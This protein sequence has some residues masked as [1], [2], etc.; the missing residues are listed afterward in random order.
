MSFASQRQ[1]DD[2]Q[3]KILACRNK[4]HASRGFGNPSQANGD[5]QKCSDQNRDACG[6]KYE[7]EFRSEGRNACDQLISR[8]P[9]NYARDF[10]NAASSLANLRTSDFRTPDTA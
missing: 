3:Q 7:S 2:L 5:L 8:R 10:I 1:C 4:S 6:F 9:R